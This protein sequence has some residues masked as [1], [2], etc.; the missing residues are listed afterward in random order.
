MQVLARG[1][2][3]VYPPAGRA[4][5]SRSRCSSPWARARSRRPSRSSRSGWRRR[6]SS[7]PA[8]KRPLPMLP[9]R[10]GVVT[11]PTG[12]VIRDILRVLRRRY[13][14]LEVLLY[15]ARVQ[16]EEAAG[17][18]RPG[19]PGPQPPRGSRRD[20]RGPRGRQP[21]GP[22]GVQRGGG[23]PGH[24]RL[25][26]PH[27]LRGGPRDRLHHR[28]LRGRRA[29]AHALGRRRAGGAGQGGAPGP[30]RRL[31]RS[32][33]D[34]GAAPAPRADAGPGRGGGRPPR[35]RRRA[36]PAAR[37]G[38]AGRRA[39]AP[40][41]DGRSWAGWSA[42]ATRSGGCG[43]GSRPSAG[44]ARSPRG[45]SGS[46]RRS[47]R[48]HALLR[49]RGRPPPRQPRPASP[50]QLDSLSPLAVLGRGYAL[51]WDE[52]AGA[53]L[54][55]AAETEAGRPAPHPTA[56]GRA[57]APPSS[58][59]SPSEEDRGDPRSSRPSASLEQIVRAP[60]EGRAAARGVAQALRGGHPAL[61][62]LPRQAGGGR[63]Q[64][65]DAAEGREGR[66][67][68]RRRRASR[69]PVPSPRPGRRV[70]TEADATGLDATLRAVGRAGAGPGAPPGDAPG[71]RPSTA[72]CATA[73]SPA[74]SASGRCWCWPRARRWA[75]PR[76]ELLPL[77]CAVEMIHTYS[78]IHDD[79]PAMDD[80][81]LR[82]GQAHLA[83]G[84]RRGDGDPGRRRA[85]DPGL[86]PP[87]RGP[88]GH[89]RRARC[90]AASRPPRSSARPAGTTGLI[91][92]QVM[93]LESEGRTIDA[94]DLERL[95][96]AKTGALL[97]ACVRGG[98]ILGGA[99]EE[100]LGRFSTAT[101]R[102][103]AS[104]SRWSTTSSTPPRRRSSSARP[105]ARTRPRARP[106]T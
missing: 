19:P 73:S 62:P 11:S 58:R 48:L 98:A 6:G 86:P 42:A 39:G 93:D 55:D 68:P 67:G 91:G 60:R 75:A 53:L 9:R 13:A 97:S 88:R 23:G 80:D 77:A 104:R 100:D 14:N 50:A 34:A 64:D 49:G 21:R 3:R 71:P 47:E 2:L 20:H 57:S 81:D 12:A 17:G 18:D 106:P 94:G 72:R 65:R 31:S 45:A 89:R 28:R 8:R 83:Q 105:R 56:P 27:D 96:R 30:D 25:A 85:A 79:L 82:R 29:R 70:P 74:A 84:L 92:G 102:P 54:R 87:G 46:A 38:P 16:G 69:R 40:G 41:G 36:G 1:R 33:C 66:A 26:R 103:S 52:A 35:L 101:P 63:G 43:S 78:L 22:L 76:E 44:T 95:H 15:P 4:T 24:R 99:S 90:G 51:V 10:I 5:R 32:G 37:P 61:A 7:T 59:G